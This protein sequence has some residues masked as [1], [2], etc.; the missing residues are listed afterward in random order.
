MVPLQFVR[1]SREQLHVPVL[2]LHVAERP[3]LGGGHPNGLGG[4]RSLGLSPRRLGRLR[5]LGLSPRCRLRGLGRRCC[6]GFFGRRRLRGLRLIFAAGRAASSLRGWLGWCRGFGHRRGHGGRSRLR[7][8]LSRLRSLGLSP[9]C[10]RGDQA[11]KPRGVPHCQPFVL[12]THFIG[13][14]PG[15]SQKKRWCHGY[16]RR[17]R[18]HLSL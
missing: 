18:L 13:R 8:W 15:K 14:I 7:L 3:L 4:L 12:K 1:V 16:S 6:D 2:P 10:S 5:S 17:Y 11:L 9:R